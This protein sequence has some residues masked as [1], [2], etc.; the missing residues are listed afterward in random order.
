MGKVLNFGKQAKTVLSVLLVCTLVVL[1][2]PL[3]ARVR[4]AGESL[5]LTATNFPGDGYH[6]GLNWTWSPAEP[7]DSVGYVIHQSGD[8]GGTW[9]TRSANYGKPVKVLN[10]YPDN[11]N[12]CV[13]K[14]WMEDSAPGMPDGAGIGLISV[15]AVSISFP[16]EQMTDTVW[17]GSPF[18]DDPDSYLKDAG[19][20]QYD[21]IMF[22]S[23]DV[24]NAKDLSPLSKAAV[25]D[26]IN[27]GRGVM[28]GHDTM[29]DSATSVNFWDL[30]SYAGIVGGSS[31]GTSDPPVPEDPGDFGRRQIKVINDGFLLQ[32]PW[33]FVVGEPLTIPRSHT[34][35]QIAT[36]TVWMEFVGFD[37]SPTT[38]GNTGNFY[39]TTNGNVSMI[40][41]GHS[42]S[43]ATDDEKKVIANTLLFL[44]QLTTETAA[45]D[46]SAQDKAAPGTPT[47]ALVGGGPNTVELTSID[48]GTAYQ[49]KIE[50]R[51]ISDSSQVAESIPVTQTSMSG[52]KEFYVYENTDDDGDPFTLGTPV[53]ATA[54]GTF[55][56]RP[57]DTG[58]ATYTI[59]DRSKYVRVVA[60]DWAGNVS[61]VMTIY[62][63]YG[64]TV[65]NDSHGTGSASPNTNVLIGTEITLTATADSGYEFK[66][67]DVVSGGVTI[68]DGE[69]T[70]P[71]DDVTVKAIF[72]VNTSQFFDVTVENDG[73]GTAAASHSTANAEEEITLTATADS[74]Y[75]FKEWDVVSGGPLTIS[76]AGK[77]SMPGNNVTVEAVFQVN[78]D[79]FF[80]VTVE[81][82]GHGTGTAAPSSANAEEEITLTATANP[83]YKFKE[84]QSGDVTISS[85]GKFT[86]PGDDVTVKAIFQVNEDEF[87]D[88][89][90]ENDGHG[91]GTAAPS[92]AN[93]EEEITLTATA[94]PGYEFKEWKVVS[95]GV[96]ISSAGK[97]N[98]P[99]D[100]VT[101][102]AVFQVDTTKFFNVTVEDDGHG[103]AAA[104]HSTANAEEEITLTATPKGY[105]KF[106]E[107]AVVS[108]GVTVTDGEFTMPGNN[109]VVKAIFEIDPTKIPA[110]VS[111]TVTSPNS[112]T[113][114]YGEGG[115]F[116]ATAIGNATVVYS[117]ADEPIGVSIDRAS[118]LITIADTTAVGI[119]TFT[120]TAVNGVWPNA[121]QDFTLTVNKAEGAP[122]DAPTLDGKTD[123]SITIIAPTDPGNGQTLEYAISTTD[124]PPDSGW[125]PDLD[126][127]EL[128][129][130]TQY[131]VFAR[132]AADDNH[133][134]GVAS[135]VLAVRTGPTPSTDTCPPTGRIKIRTSYWRL[136]LNKLTFG[137]FFKEPV[138][139]KIIA[140][141]DDSGVAKVEHFISKKK[142]PDTTDWNT[143]NWT[144]GDS[145]AMAF[146]CR[147]YVYAQI[148]DNAG[149]ETVI[150]RSKGRWWQFWR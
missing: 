75:E 68:T 122:V 9:E 91:T 94:N 61:P 125:S 103:T 144:A 12:S 14:G 124:T 147:S 72:Q 40:Q 100:D 139:V 116:Q 80:N 48:A 149:N 11:P 96:T 105:Y 129:A 77:F 42:G 133:E 115:A 16:S 134:V 21:V 10:V 69:F 51:K 60:V 109:V 78:E 65:Q 82:D 136:I 117:L 130:D 18:N 74:G 67:W 123:T 32:Y 27:S 106:K 127:T 64:V 97:F 13:M 76:S 71:G 59:Q 140:K 38:P 118:G 102:E 3:A 56:T 93:A 146:Q 138:A 57:G 8:S 43:L 22:G 81:D 29:Y 15:D 52:I 55:D 20:Y 85:A 142:L 7:S 86:M 95:G 128:S 33:Q 36:G 114:T 24:N 90:V 34:T 37:G 148:T 87:F 45:D 110:S 121:R 49:Y 92:S 79:E 107:W 132:A 6:M 120:I 70:M 46:Y 62:S 108:G 35:G 66:Q 26:F 113:V 137:Y 47:Y 41:T 141:D 111:P 53:S 23:A 143:I 19:E 4:A 99:G 112:M 63:P 54:L 135:E 58:T 83:G 104:S 17:T 131:Y 145:F 28:F 150:E 89:T 98:M 84:W 101:V 30:R 126:F 119:Y 25:V 88:V 44:A 1:A 2:A 39:L 5:S 50:A 73:H 31:F